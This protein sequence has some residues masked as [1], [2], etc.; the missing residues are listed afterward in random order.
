MDV[1]MTSL[2]DLY[3]LVALLIVTNKLLKENIKRLVKIYMKPLSINANS[4]NGKL[5]LF[6]NCLF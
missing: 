5:L 2:K 6:L 3:P 1:S 4:S